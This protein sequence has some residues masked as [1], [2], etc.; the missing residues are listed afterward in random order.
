LGLVIGFPLILLGSYLATRK[1]PTFESEP[2]G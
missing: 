1:A 2:I